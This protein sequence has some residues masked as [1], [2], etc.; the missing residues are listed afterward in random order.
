[1]KVSEAMTRKVSLVSPTQTICDAAKMMAE[2]DA[3]SLPVAENDRLVGMITDRDI[4][5]RA[6]AERRSPDTP[7]RDVMSKEILYCFDDEDIDHVARNMAEQQVRRLPVV[8]RDK[9]LVGIVSIGDISHKGDTRT[10][11]GAMKGITQP[12]GAHDQTTGSVH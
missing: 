6:V 8:N 9:R 7:V 3:G 10:A 4:A 1:M 2:C 12:G 5:I 11:G